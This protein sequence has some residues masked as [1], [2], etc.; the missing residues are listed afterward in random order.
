M[1]NSLI[2]K[3]N[4]IRNSESKRTKESKMA[5]AIIKNYAKYKNREI[6]LQYEGYRIESDMTKDNYPYN[7]VKIY[8]LSKNRILR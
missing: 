2:E 4:A 5:N 7:G 6:Q 1:R 3:L 8:Q